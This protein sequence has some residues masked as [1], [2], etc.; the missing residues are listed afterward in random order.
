MLDLFIVLS[1]VW[2]LVGFIVMGSSKGRAEETSIY[3]WSRF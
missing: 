1:N 3:S 2:Y